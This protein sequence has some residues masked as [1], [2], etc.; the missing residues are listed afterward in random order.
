[1]KNLFVAFTGIKEGSQ[2]TGNAVIEQANG[3]VIALNDIRILE[4]YICKKYNYE[5][6]VIV[7]FRRME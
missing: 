6:V 5:S 4:E 2:Y 3:K 7:N 1:M